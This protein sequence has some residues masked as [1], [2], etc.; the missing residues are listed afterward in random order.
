MND[1]MNAVFDQFLTEIN[2][3]AKFLAGEF[4]LREALSKVNRYHLLNSFDLNHHQ[5]GH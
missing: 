5:S 3:K 2:D 4:Q 1:T